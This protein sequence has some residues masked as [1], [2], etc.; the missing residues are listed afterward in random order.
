MPLFMFVIL[1]GL[2]TRPPMTAAAGRSLRRM[3]RRYARCGSGT[4]S[5]MRPVLSSS[6]PCSPSRR[7]CMAYLVSYPWAAISSGR[8][9]CAPGC[10]VIAAFW[11]LR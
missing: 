9:V 11:P 2:S 5:V 4:G 8:L 6:M 3:E 7:A 1:F 10:P